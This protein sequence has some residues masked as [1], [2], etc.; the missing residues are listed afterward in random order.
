MVAFAITVKDAAASRVA[1]V[2]AA[3]GGGVLV[4]C[5]WVL[6]ICGPPGRTFAHKSDRVGG[7]AADR[8]DVQLRTTLSTN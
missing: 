8:I 3:G 5:I 4:A 6:P 1:P 7:Q 2:S